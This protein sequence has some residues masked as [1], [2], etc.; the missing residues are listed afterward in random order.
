MALNDL[1]V[2]E[3]TLVLRVLEQLG[4]IKVLQLGFV[5]RCTQFVTNLNSL[6]SVHPCL[7]RSYRVLA[8]AIE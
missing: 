1:L 8:E 7:R 5:S 3:W 4:L 2:W 6:N